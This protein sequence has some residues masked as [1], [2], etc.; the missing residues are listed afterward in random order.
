MLRKVAISEQTN[1]NIAKTEYM[2][3]ATPPKLKSLDYSPLIK[4]N[5]KLMKH[6]L[7]SD[8][9]GLIVDERRS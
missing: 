4:L 7:K 8:Y 2:I 3:I 6:V 5:G 1:P 9:L